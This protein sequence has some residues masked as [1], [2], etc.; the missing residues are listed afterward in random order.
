MK[1]LPPGRQWVKKEVKRLKKNA[2]AVFKV[3]ASGG[4][5]KVD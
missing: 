4:W 1:S 2:T 5:R 3:G